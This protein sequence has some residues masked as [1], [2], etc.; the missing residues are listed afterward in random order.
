MRSPTNDGINDVT[1]KYDRNVRYKC[2][3]C[4][5]KFPKKIDLITHLRV[6][7]KEKGPRFKCGICFYVLE[8]EDAYIEHEKLHENRSPLECVYCNKVLTKKDG[9]VKHMLLHSNETLYQCHKCGKTF[10]HVTS[11]DSHMNA[12][13]DIRKQKCTIC[14]K[15]F[16]NI[17]HLNRH[18]QTHVSSSKLKRLIELR[19]LLI[20]YLFF[21]DRHKTI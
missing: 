1:E 4:D 20:F 5:E 6:H 12:H 15:E 7:K 21:A 9:L 8:N 3:E 17:S 11:F 13:D 2:Y 18:K 16:R 19:W 14:S 10:V